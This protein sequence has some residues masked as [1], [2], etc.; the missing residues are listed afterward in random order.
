MP[1][2][3]DSINSKFFINNKLTAFLAILVSATLLSACGKKDADVA[4]IRPALVVKLAPGTAA[5]VD[6]LTGEIRARVEADHAFRVGGKIMKRLVDA[7]ASVKR[8][9]ALAQLDPQDV[10]LSADAA[11]AQVN[12]LQTET[13]F[14]EAELKRFRDLKAQGF[15]SQ[16]ALDQK[17]NQANATRARLDAQKAS[18]NVAI[19]QAG[20]ATLVAEMDGVVTHVLAE[21]GQVVAAGQPVMRLANP[22]EREL[23][24]A[25]PESQLAQFR[26]QAAQLRDIKVSLWSA[27]EKKYSARIREIAGA[28]DTVTRTYAARLGI[29]NADDAV[30][31]GMSA[32]ATFSGA[33]ISGTY[34]VPLSALYVNTKGDITGVWLVTKD[35]RVSL[36]P[37]KVIQ[38][39][40]T[41]ALIHTESIKPGDDI[42]AAGVHK[43]R[44]GEVIKPISD[45]QVK[46]DGKIAYAVE[47]AA[48]PQTQLA[49]QSWFSR[50]IQ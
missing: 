1:Y 44:E 31:L 16:S 21:A 41:T 11:R 24:I 27:P 26:K 34:S 36:K 29:L 28:A 33:D 15:V 10:K 40:E 46:G 13:D 14:A 38:Y 42:I 7:G 35:S 12:A 17:I 25:I 8:G 5:D 43:L 39:R 20:Y 48:A 50:L 19:N 23:Q 45:S 18:A 3:T 9:Q 30:G 37:V 22:R 32:F 6:I 2:S 4:P 47:P 49:T